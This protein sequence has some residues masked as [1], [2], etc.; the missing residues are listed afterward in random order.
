VPFSSWPHSG[1]RALSPRLS[2]RLGRCSAV[3]MVLIA[4]ALLTACGDDGD[5]ES[6]D[7]APGGHEAPRG[8]V[9]PKPDDATPMNVTLREWSVVLAKNNV[10]PGKV[11]FLAENAGP[12]HPH[13]LVV[14]RTDLGPLNLPFEQNTIPADQVDIVGEVEEFAPHSS[15][16]LTVELTPGKYLLVCNIT[17]EDPAIGSHYKKGMVAVLTVE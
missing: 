4:V 2:A 7:H 6:A 15:A 8:V 13:E 17:E 11:Y 10:K 3:L 12:D 1:T 16:S 9:S 14:I 5:E